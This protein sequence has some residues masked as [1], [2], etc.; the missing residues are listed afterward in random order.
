MRD[1]LLSEKKK[2]SPI[3]LRNKAGEKNQPHSDDTK[4]KDR[5]LE[6]LPKLSRKVVQ[7]DRSP[8]LGSDSEESDKNRAKVKDKRKNKRSGRQEV[9]SDEESSYDSYAE[10]RKEAKRRRRREEKKMRKEE[11]RWRREEKRRRKEERREGKQKLKSGGTV[12]TPSDTDGKHDDHFGDDQA[13]K[14]RKS[15]QDGMDE[16]L[17]EQKKLEIELREKAIE[18]Y[19]AKK[20]ISH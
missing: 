9:E 14:R 17:T 15:G 16:P 10:E 13:V 5:H 2:E 6:N 19:M 11:K 7:N 12:S 1:T 18:L 3:K 4:L 8:S 20:G